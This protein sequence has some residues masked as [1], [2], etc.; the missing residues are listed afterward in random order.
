MHHQLVLFCFP[1][2]PDATVHLRSALLIV[3]E[4]FKL[5]DRHAFFASHLR[6]FLCSSSSS[7]RLCMMPHS[8][9]RPAPPRGPAIF[10]ARGLFL[11]P[12]THQRMATII[13]SS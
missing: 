12:I 9:T 4:L 6:S 8:T 13:A 7:H 2:L 1:D 3:P 5:L 11:L 10:L